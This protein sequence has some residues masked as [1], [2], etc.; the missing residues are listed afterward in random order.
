MNNPRGLLSIRG[1]DR[2]PKAEI[3]KMYRVIKGVDKRKDESS[4]MV[5]PY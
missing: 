4:L 5:K 1:M 2:E 3:R